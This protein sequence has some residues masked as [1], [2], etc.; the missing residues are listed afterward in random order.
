MLL[1]KHG[2][3]VF[4]C[5]SVSLITC[6]ILFSI[7]QSMCYVL[8]K[9]WLDWISVVGVTSSLNCLLNCIMF[10][11]SIRLIISFSTNNTTQNTH[12]YAVCSYYQ[13]AVIVNSAAQA[14]KL[15]EPPI[16]E[17]LTERQTQFVSGWW[18]NSRTSAE[19][20]LYQRN[21]N[22]NL[23]LFSSARW[24]STTWP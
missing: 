2:T 12:F 23:P 13:W 17:Q 14:A 22:M 4:Y 20:G 9:Q 10:Q 19:T 15:S 7:Q 24:T 21:A 8:R 6:W 11:S 1:Y 3:N 5:L 18:C 16:V